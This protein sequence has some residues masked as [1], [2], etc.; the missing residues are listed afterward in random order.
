MILGNHEL[1]MERMLDEDFD[2]IYAPHIKELSPRHWTPIHVVKRATDFLCYKENQKILDVGSGVG[3]F[4]TVGGLLKKDSFFYGVEYRK[5]FIEVSDQIKA[6]Y[7]LKNVS[8]INKDFTELDFNNF[9]GIYFFN[10]FH[11]RIDSECIIDNYS[12]FSYELYKKY[13]QDFFPKL[14]NMP[15]GSR[16]VTYHTE[17]IYIPYDY[18]IVD[19]Q[20]EGKLKFYIK[21]LEAK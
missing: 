8:F 2:H 3:K 5:K 7:R 4:C 18:R 17:D 19:H 13:T 14:N 20:I 16:L 21:C 9:D 10:S 11:E 15:E 1:P 12:E 6:D